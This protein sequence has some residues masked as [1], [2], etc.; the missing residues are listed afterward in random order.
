MCQL[1][2]LRQMH[3]R[4]DRRQ[5]EHATPCTNI[6]ARV[7]HFAHGPFRHHAPSQW[8]SYKAARHQEGIE[9]PACTFIVRRRFAHHRSIVFSAARIASRL[10]PPIEPSNGLGDV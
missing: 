8:R 10:G 1:R 2:L 9:A 7:F 6:A 4:C 5:H 3:P